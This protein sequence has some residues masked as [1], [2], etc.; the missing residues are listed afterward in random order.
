[1]E[2][3][4]EPEKWPVVTS[5]QQFQGHIIT[6]RTDTVRM[7]DGKEVERDYVEHPGAVGIVAL[8]EADRV[9]LV[10]QYRHP[11]GWRL[12]ELPAGLLDQPGENPLAAA[13]REL[14]EEAH[15]QAADWRVLVDMFTT[16]GSSDEAIRIFLARGVTDADGE[17]YAREHEEAD[18]HT[19]WADRTEVTKLILAGELHNPLAVAGVLALTSVIAAGG[20]EDLRPADA[21]WPQRPY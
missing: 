3:R 19:L 7:P 12:W 16:P 21:P 1:M 5:Q 2:I 11:V 14:Y 20:L 9:L 18:M 6:A 8:D 13:K 15:Q 17:Q 10:R 4:D